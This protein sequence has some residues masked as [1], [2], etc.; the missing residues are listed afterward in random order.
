MTQNGD[1]KMKEFEM[2]DVGN[3]YGGLNVKEVD[4]KYFWAIENYDGTDF[5]EIPKALYDELLKHYEAS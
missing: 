1:T 4:G 3:Y 2:K 5:E